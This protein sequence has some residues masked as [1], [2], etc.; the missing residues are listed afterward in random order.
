MPRARISTRSGDRVGGDGRHEGVE[1]RADLGEEVEH[2][3]GV[4]LQDLLPQLRVA[5]RDARDVADALAREGEVLGRGRCQPSGDEHGGEVRQVGDAGDGPVV[6]PRLHHQRR[7]PA[8]QHQCLDEA[9]GVGAC[10]GVRR[11]G[12]GTSVEEGRAGGEGAGALAAGHRVR[13]DVAGEVVRSDPAGHLLEGG[14]L[15]AADVGDDGIGAAQGVDDGVADRGGRHGHHDQLR[16]VVRRR[17]ASR[18]EAVGGAEVLLGG[19]AQ[20]DLDA[21]PTAHQG[22]R[23]ADQARTDDLHRPGQGRQVVVSHGWWSGRGRGAGWPRRGGR[24]G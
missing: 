6:L 23:R 19:V 10:V 1:V 20:H 22:D 14:G 13:A 4:G 8:L 18:P 17:H 2:G 21:E 5:R 11:D 12:P 16:S 3:L 24:R 9:Y 7:G 15:D